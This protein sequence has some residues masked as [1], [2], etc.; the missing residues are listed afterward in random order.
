MGTYSGVDLSVAMGSSRT[1][2]FA[3]AWSAGRKVATQ[4]HLHEMCR[5]SSIQIVYRVH[6]RS[7]CTDPS[8]FKS[9]N[10]G[11][12]S[13]LVATGCIIQTHHHSWAHSHDKHDLSF[14]HI[15]FR[16]QMR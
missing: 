14:I 15:V 16:C 1:W 5:R 6:A 13:H 12:S 11:K 10:S 8:T 7:S 9:E 2:W 3:S 4:D